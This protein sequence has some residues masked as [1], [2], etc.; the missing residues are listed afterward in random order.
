MRK[1]PTFAVATTLLF[2]TAF[3]APGP[4][5][6]TTLDDNDTP[7]DTSDD[8][9]YCTVAAYIQCTEAVGGKVQALSPFVSA[10]APLGPDRPETSFTAGAGCGTYENSPATGA[11]QDNIHDFVFGGRVKANIDSLAVELH[12]IYAG[13]ERGSG[14]IELGVRVSIGGKSPF[15]TE[16]IELA[17]G[18][19]EV[20]RMVRV[21]AAATPSST[22]LSETFQFTITGLAD[23]IGTVAPGT[24]T[25]PNRE[26]KISID[27][28]TGAHVFVWG[29][30]EVP[31]GVLLNPAVPLG[32]VVPANPTAG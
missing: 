16:T 31:A 10:V 11:T 24:I 29:A 7:A 28:P 3:T 26:I 9:G 17:T 1:L 27:G 12:D 32:T 22:G 8:T 18:P 30:S 23:A 4:D 6:C 2:G 20:P 25:G 15:G 19:I 21:Q 14:A 13:P 5:E